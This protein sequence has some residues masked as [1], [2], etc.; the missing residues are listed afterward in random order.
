MSAIMRTPIVRPTAAPTKCS[1]SAEMSGTGP[2]SQTTLIPLYVEALSP[3]HGTTARHPYGPGARL[4]PSMYGQMPSVWA[5]GSQSHRGIYS[6]PS[7]LLSIM[8][9]ALTGTATTAPTAELSLLS[10]SPAA[11]AVG[12]TSLS[13]RRGQAPFNPELTD[14]SHAGPSASR[15]A[16]FVGQA[17]LSG[18]HA[19]TSLAQS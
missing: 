14:G 9:S 1:T 13:G 2:T 7:V 8:R 18:A 4:R 6:T 19:E 17:L 16:F 10:S 11:P 15:S 12:T 5:P 3:L